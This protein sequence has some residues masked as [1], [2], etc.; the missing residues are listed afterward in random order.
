M[1][2]I[3][4][5]KESTK[6]T[7]IRLNVYAAQTT[8]SRKKETNNASS[9]L[10]TSSAFER[11]FLLLSFFF[12]SHSY[13]KASCFA[14]PVALISCFIFNLLAYDHI[15]IAFAPFKGILNAANNQLTTQTTYT[16][17]K[18][19]CVSK[20]C[21]TNALPASKSFVLLTYALR[22]FPSIELNCYSSEC[23]NNVGKN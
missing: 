1:C 4:T 15:F 16:I 21:S 8:A 17:K 19:S 3:H 11:N 20:S 9:I 5:V 6:N 18:E 14:L 23:I 22:A 2:L 12:F 10:Q 13:I 7:I